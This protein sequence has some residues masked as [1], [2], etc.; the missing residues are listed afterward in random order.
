MA[1]LQNSTVRLLN[2]SD[3]ADPLCPLPALLGPAKQSACFS[4]CNGRLEVDSTA[5]LRYF[6]E[7]PKN[8]NLRD[9]LSQF[10][11]LP[12]KDRAFKRA[13]RL[14][15]VFT[16]CLHSENSEELLKAQV[17]TWRGIVTKLMKGEKLDLNVSYYH[18]VLYLE[19]VVPR[20]QYNNNS[21]GTYTGH[22]FES[23]CST[24]FANPSGD[25][26]VDG[27]DLHTLWNAA[28]TRTLGSLDILLVGEVDCV[29][30]GYAQNPGP[31]NYV[32]LKTRKADG[33]SY[34][35]INTL[36]TKIQSYLLGTREIFVGFPDS[37][38]IVRNVKT[39]GADFIQPPQAKVD[40][41][42]RVLHSLRAFCARSA[43][44]DG[45]IKVWRV[46][47]RSKY[48]DVRELSAQEVQKMNKG[49]V[50][51]NGIIPVSFL[52]G[53]KKKRGSAV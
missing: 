41:G 17:V 49:G 9:G 16:T 42:A 20:V 32:E 8:A 14:D 29:K 39:Y 50:R 37:M 13:R 40:W 27:V 4:I 44:A 22:K 18:G 11:K 2:I 47:A 46:E 26:Q 15:N 21:E 52:E 43:N 51:R 36:K 45:P 6:V 38:G 5:A 10:L 25:R 33:D 53:L 1:L 34:I 24:S 30:A 3:P 28:I 35:M 48:I 7:P 23:F 19:E 12:K 31:E